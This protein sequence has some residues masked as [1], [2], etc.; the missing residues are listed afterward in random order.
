MDSRNLGWVE[1]VTGKGAGE[2][3]EG[4]RERVSQRERARD[5]E[6]S[7]RRVNVFHPISFGR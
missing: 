6:K 5:T 1:R 3:E 7:C 4:E 2:R